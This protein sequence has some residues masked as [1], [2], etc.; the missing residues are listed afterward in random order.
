MAFEK[1]RSTQ[2]RNLVRPCALLG[3]E[4]LLSTVV[5]VA[6][7]WCTSRSKPPSGAKES[8]SDLEGATLPE[9]IGKIK[10]FPAGVWPEKLWPEG[11]GPLS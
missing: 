5:D 1:S 7:S 4:C 6:T 10:S 8:N 9:G 2:E 11:Y 3:S